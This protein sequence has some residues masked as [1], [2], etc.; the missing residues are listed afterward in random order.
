MADSDSARSPEPGSRDG[1]GRSRSIGRAIATSLVVALLAY[2]IGVGFYSVVPTLFWPE[3][4]EVAEDVSCADGLADLRAELFARAGDRVAS[5]GGERDALR[6]WLRGWDRRHLAFEARCEDQHDAWQLL[7]RL[8]QRVQGTLERFDAH[9]RELARDLDRTL[10][11]GSP[12][13]R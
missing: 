10:A 4:I 3:T 6:S 11:Q 5:G 12:R 13:R 2:L 1:R 9:E 8:R 7:G